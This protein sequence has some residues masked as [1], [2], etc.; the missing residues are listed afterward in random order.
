VGALFWAGTRHIRFGLSAARLGEISTPLGATPYAF[1]ITAAELASASTRP[2]RV[3][4]PIR[5]D[6]AAQAH[7]G[8][9]R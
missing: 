3:D 2:M 9:W 5:E 1:T 4:G 7:H 8:F 6:E